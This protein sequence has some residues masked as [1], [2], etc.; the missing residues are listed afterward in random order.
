MHLADVYLT[1]VAGKRFRFRSAHDLALLQHALAE[2]PF[3]APKGKQEE[4]WARVAEIL[5]ENQAIPDGV[6][7]AGVFCSVE[8]LNSDIR[9]G[10]FSFDGT[11]ISL[12]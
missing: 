12:P 7:G 9:T 3:L 6:T 1:A 8:S 4:C 11:A 5:K 2:E 10:R